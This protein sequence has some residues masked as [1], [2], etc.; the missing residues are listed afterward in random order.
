MYS[1]E[2]LSLA[3][4]PSSNA[5]LTALSLVGGTGD[6]AKWYVGDQVIVERLMLMVTTT[7][8]TGTAAPVVTFYARPTF[9][10][11]SGQITLGTLTI[12]TATAAGSIVYKNIESVKLPM[13]YTLVA[14]LTT[15]GTDGG[16]A[17]GAGL[18]MFKM[19]QATEEPKNISLMIASV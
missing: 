1:E 10:S 11:T 8:L 18:V 4:A 2:T 14:N 7:T 15:A 6:Y 5:Y 9:G 16:S 3:I 12:P 17:A 13:G 19:F